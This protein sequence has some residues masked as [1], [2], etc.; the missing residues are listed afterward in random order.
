MITVGVF[1]PNIQI[2][3][4]PRYDSL[5]NNTSSFLTAV[6][7][8][9]TSSVHELESSGQ[10]GQHTHTHIDVLKKAANH[11]SNSYSNITRQVK[12]VALTIDINKKGACQA[13]MG[14]P[15][16]SRLGNL[17]SGGRDVLNCQVCHVIFVD[18]KKGFV[19]YAIYIYYIIYYKIINVDIF[20]ST[21]YYDFI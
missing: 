3:T 21:V 1:G 12:Q 17:G 11:I 5:G 10:K 13:A 16:L 18:Y 2:F 19:H 14:V 4:R 9:C 6:N 8:F 15:G 7:L 20:Y